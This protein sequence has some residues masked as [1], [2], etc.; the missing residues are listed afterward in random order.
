MNSGKGGVNNLICPKCDGVMESGIIADRTEDY[1]K[2]KLQWGKSINLFWFLNQ[3]SDTEA[4]K[5]EKCGFIEL[6][7]RKS[8]S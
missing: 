6:Y 4:F 3:A 8:K 1:G 5:C 7:S 2:Q